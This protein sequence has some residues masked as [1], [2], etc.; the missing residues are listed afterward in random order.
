MREGGCLHG[1]RA[2]DPQ[3]SKSILNRIFAAKNPRFLIKYKHSKQ[4][5]FL[6]MIL[7]VGKNGDLKERVRGSIASNQG[8]H[9]LGCD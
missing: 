8:A 4:Q 1:D 3:N 9:H 5:T 2:L 7:L 6:T